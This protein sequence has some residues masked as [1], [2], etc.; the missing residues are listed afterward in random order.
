M[1]STS[2]TEKHGLLHVAIIMDGS[3]RWATERGLA[4]EA[5]HCAGRAA[6]ERTVEAALRLGIN[7]LTLFAFSGDNWHRPAREVGN[8]LRV[9]EDY[10]HAVA[11]DYPGRGV[12]LNVIG[13]R[14]RLS[15]PLLESIEAAERATRAGQALQ[16]RIAL[17]Y[18]GRE[19]I[20]RASH[21]LRN[22]RP[23]SPE[24]FRE[25]LAEAINAGEPVP[26]IDLL[27]RTGG[28]QRL[29]D[30]MLWE[31]AYAEMVFTPCLWP[32]FDATQLEGAMREFHGRERRFGRIVE[33]AAG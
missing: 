15:P 10:F 9:F 33:A 20:L 12:R 3:G 26:D 17:D 32:D 18:S 22:G 28:E 7:T 25:A 5:G 29:S 30:F 14:D 13:R 27:I 23:P 8:L 6:A 19:A 1:Q 16:L 2:R 24:A 4:R 11:A 31:C 21:R